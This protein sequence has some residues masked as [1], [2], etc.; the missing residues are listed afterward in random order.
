MKTRKMIACLMLFVLLLT[1]M[2]ARAESPVDDPVEAAVANAYRQL[3][4]Y[5]VIT[6]EDGIY[7]EGC[8]GNRSV[9]E[10]TDELLI[11]GFDIQSIVILRLADDCELLFPD[12]T[13]EKL[14]LAGPEA[15]PQWYQ[16]NLLSWC[17]DRAFFAYFTLNEQLMLSRLEYYGDMYD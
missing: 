8:F 6:A 2:T 5:D 17:T 12:L 13:G 16:D 4:I 14:L 10:A 3:L 11:E 15:L 1:G 7:V 9:D